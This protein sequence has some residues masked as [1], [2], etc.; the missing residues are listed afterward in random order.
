[1]ELDRKNRIFKLI[2]EDFIKTAVPVGSNYLI[3][4]YKLPYSSATVRNE[5]VD[6]ENDGLIEKT[7]TSSGRVPSVLGYKYYV[8]YLKN[9]SVDSKLKY[10]LKVVFDNSKS[11][12]EV[13]D[14]SCKIL[15]NMEPEE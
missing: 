15:S 12:E 6:L 4:K 8:K 7:H 10:Q 5:M 9:D 13:L 14:E 2:V 11:V 3:S 1:M